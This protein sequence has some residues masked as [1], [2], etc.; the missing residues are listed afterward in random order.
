MDLF[1]PQARFP[2]I[3]FWDYEFSP[4]VL[5]IHKKNP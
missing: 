4:L 1:T 3:S 5:H 2:F